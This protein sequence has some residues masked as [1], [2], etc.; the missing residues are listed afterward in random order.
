MNPNSDRPPCANS[1]SR[2]PQHPE[3]VSPMHVRIAQ[4]PRVVPPAQP[5]DDFLARLDTF[6]NPPPMTAEQRM[7]F[8]L[9]PGSTRPAPG[10]TNPL[11]QAT[12]RLMSG[13]A[14]LIDS[15]LGS[16][17]LV[18]LSLIGTFARRQGGDHARATEAILRSLGLDAVLD[19][20]NDSLRALCATSGVQLTL[21]G[22]CSLPPKTLAFAIALG[23]SL[24]Q[25]YLKETENPDIWVSALVLEQGKEIGS[26]GIGYLKFEEDEAEA[27]VS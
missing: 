19:F 20:D 25:D 27:P 11:H 21:Q 26:L 22:I 23:L 13:R 16:N 18:A 10:I 9:S 1:C 12:R 8:L 14:F 4:L 5:L 24:T 17:P 15:P 3:Y 2:S 7:R 6:V